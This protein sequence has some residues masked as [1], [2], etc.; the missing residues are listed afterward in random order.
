MDRK[1]GKPVGTKS[2]RGRRRQLGRVD[3]G[4]TKKSVGKPS[5][6]TF[7]DLLDAVGAKLAES[8]ERK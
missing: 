2:D 1:Q 7:A 3:V 6:C 5:V 4:H 8:G